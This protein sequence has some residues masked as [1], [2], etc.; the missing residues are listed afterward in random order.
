[1]NTKKTLFAASAAFILLAAFPAYSNATNGGEKTAKA[2]ETI[3]PLTQGQLSV[4]YTGS[5]ENGVRFNVQFENT[6]AQH[7]Q[8]II[9]NPEGDI[10]YQGVF[11]DVHFNKTIQFLPEED[12]LNPTFIIRAGKQE[13]RH[14][15][16]VNR[17]VV[18][19]VVV[20]KL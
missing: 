19:N 4:Q 5:N 3:T 13:I 20:T 6:G 7:F 8:L 2:K 16:T 1:M 12:Q 15:F 17:K 10:L 11:S 18:E 14:S 9:K